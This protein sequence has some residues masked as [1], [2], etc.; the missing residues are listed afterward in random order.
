MAFARRVHGAGETIVSSQT[1]RRRFSRQGVLTVLLV[2]ASV[3]IALG[4]FLAGAMWRARVTSI[5][6]T[7]SVRAADGGAV[8]QPLT[9]HAS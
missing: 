3:L 2:I 9:N 1:M 5:A 7:S 4:L 6:R 8:P